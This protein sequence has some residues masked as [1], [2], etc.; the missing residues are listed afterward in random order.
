MGAKR[1]VNVNNPKEMKDLNNSL[2]FILSTIPTNY[3]M[4]MYLKMLKYD[5]QMAIV[6][7]PAFVNMPA[8]SIDKFIWQGNRKIFGSQIG[9]IKETQKMLDYS[10]KNNIYQEVKIINAE[11]VLVDNAYQNV[12]DGKVKFRYVIDMKTLK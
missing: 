1:Y 4:N 6:G 7:L 3:D 10:V 8:I 9:G 12:L 2:D 5:G 11:G